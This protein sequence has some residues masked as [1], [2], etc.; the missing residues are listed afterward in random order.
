MRAFFAIPVPAPLA[1]AIA[2]L[3]RGLPGARPVAAENLHLTLAFLGDLDAGALEAAHE[4]AAGVSCPRFAVAFDGLGTFG[5]PLPATLWIGLQPSA[6]LAAL[7]RTLRHRLHGAG[8]MLPRS[9]FLPHVTIAR[10]RR[11]MPPAWLAEL[12]DRIAERMRPDLPPLEVT[13]FALVSSV[14]RPEGPIH[15][16]LAH[17]PLS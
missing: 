4:A 17:Y 1:E 11:A 10:F 2:P 7:H 8:L 14:L 13:S 9:R 5:H 6:P 3:Q 15:E 16:P 12:Q